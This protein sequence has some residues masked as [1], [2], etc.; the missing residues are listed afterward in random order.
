[1]PTSAMAGPSGA[2]PSD[3][4]ARASVAIPGSHGPCRLK[5]H[6]ARLR[7]TDAPFQTR[8]I[9]DGM[10]VGARV[11]IDLV[12]H[13]GA[14]FAVLH[15][16]MLGAESTGSGSIRDL[17]ADALLRLD[18]KR[19]D[20]ALTGERVDTLAS[21]MAKLAL[22][23]TLHPEALLQLDLKDV[24]ADINA[25]SY[26]A[27]ASA[28][29]PVARNLIL[30]GEDHTAL[31]RLAAEVPDLHLG[32]DPCSAQE[33]ARLAEDRDFAGFVQRALDAMPEARILYIEHAVVLA[34]A[35]S[36]INLAEILRGAGKELDAY[37]L[38]GAGPADVATARRLAALGVSQIT[39]DDP[40]G[41]AAAFNP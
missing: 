5:W 12:N 16:L 39:A 23:G 3:P 27:F 9:L 2:A 10:A 38:R 34:A 14:G 26:A 4:Q 17:E 32:F 6:R 8:R 31:R 24:S 15:D 19:P 25:G 28:V 22:A 20:G 13:R 30:S 35:E 21:L 18:R 29:T 37:T 33:L 1:M 41:L 40:A 36:G 7:A 11:E